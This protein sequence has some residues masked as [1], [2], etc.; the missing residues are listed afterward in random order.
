MKDFRWSQSH[1]W[2]QYKVWWES[3][4]TKLFS[5][6]IVSPQITSKRC[7]RFSRLTKNPIKVPG[8][9]NYHI[10]KQLNVQWAVS[11]KVFFKKFVPSRIHIAKDGFT[12]RNSTKNLMPMNM[13]HVWRHASLHCTT[14]KVIFCTCCSSANSIRKRWFCIFQFN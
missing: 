2:K 8:V 7:L 13:N 9:K 5:E 1:P 12:P 3:L 10:W 4:K 6:K 11:S 14:R